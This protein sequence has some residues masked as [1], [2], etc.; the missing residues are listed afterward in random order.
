MKPKTLYD[1]WTDG[2]YRADSACGGAA[3]L[4]V[5]GDEKRSDSIALSHLDK[6]S[7]PHGSDIAE[8]VAVG[9]ALRSIPPES[10]V[11]LRIDAQNIIDWL[12]AGRLG[13]K[14]KAPQLQSAFE[15]AIEGIN[16]M[17]SVEITKV[18]GK[19]NENLNFVND[20]ARK[21]S[22]MAARA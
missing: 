16:K 12:N 4:I 10:N 2:S 22:G 7:K 19:K 6:N 17:S 1:V 3:W 13:S 21:T 14:A 8:L 18:S 20:L 9:S 5:H 11:H 15:S